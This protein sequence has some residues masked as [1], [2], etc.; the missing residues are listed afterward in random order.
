M[1]TIFFSLLLTGLATSAF[2]QKIKVENDLVTVDGQPYARI[3]KDGCGMMDLDCS[4]HVKS[5]QNQQLFTVK[6]V[7]F[8]DPGQISASNPEGRTLYLQYIFTASRTTAETSFP[9]TLHL[10]ALDVARK[11]YQAHLLK[12]GTL[13]AEVAD[14]FVLDKGTPFSQRRREINPQ[15]IV[16]PSGH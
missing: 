3:E 6:Q 4:Y 14:T 15:V 13:D 10:R 8:N 1:K 16:V 9:A 12:E 11:V 7:I 5:L 2:A